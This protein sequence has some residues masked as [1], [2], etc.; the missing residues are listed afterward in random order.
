[1]FQIFDNTNWYKDTG[2]GVLRF[3]CYLSGYRPEFHRKNKKE[4]DRIELKQNKI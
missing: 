3:F 1:M 2:V 4:A